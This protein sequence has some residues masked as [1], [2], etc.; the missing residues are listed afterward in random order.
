M[1]MDSF[2]EVGGETRC[3]ILTGITKLYEEN[4]K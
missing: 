2:G 3:I 1:L 4:T